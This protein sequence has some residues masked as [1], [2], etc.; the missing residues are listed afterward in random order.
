MENVGNE[1][2]IWLANSLAFAFIILLVVIIYFLYWVTTE[3][4]LNYQIRSNKY[5]IERLQI[6]LDSKIKL[7]ERKLSD[8]FNEGYSFGYNDG[9]QKTK[10]KEK[11]I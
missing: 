1:I 2:N 10:E 8:T 9:L 5:S 4:G 7:K 11:K 3:D 6:K